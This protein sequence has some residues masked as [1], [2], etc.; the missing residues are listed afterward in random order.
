MKSSQI[1]TGKAVFRF[2]GVN[3]RVIPW[4]DKALLISCMEENAE[5]AR[6]QILRGLACLNEAQY[7]MWEVSTNPTHD[8]C[9]CKS[10]GNTK[11]DSQIAPSNGR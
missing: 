1:V 3:L 10:C 8:D 11:E 6:G 2:H 7:L 9:S 5:I 4:M